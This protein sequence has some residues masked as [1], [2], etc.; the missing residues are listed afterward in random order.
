MRTVLLLPFCC[1]FLLLAGCSTT[2]KNLQKQVLENCTWLL[3]EIDGRALEAAPIP[4]LRTPTLFLDAQTKRAA[5]VAGVNRY[6]AGYEHEGSQL[7]FGQA[8][9]TRMAGPPQA[10]ETEQAFLDAIQA[11]TSW[12]FDDGRLV[13]YADG[14]ARLRFRP[15]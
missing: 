6:T 15:E 4:G 3:V 14:E 2:D 8:A 1:L 11:V 12:S 10:M 7:L 9:A 5:G 13:L